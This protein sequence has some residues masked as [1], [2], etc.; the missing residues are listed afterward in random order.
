MAAVIRR[1]TEL[2]EKIGDTGID[3]L[4]AAARRD[5]LAVDRRMIRDFLSTGAPAQIHRP[6]PESKGKTGSEAQGFRVQADLIDFKRNP[7]TFQGKTWTVI[8]VIIDVQ[9]R[10]VWAK[11]CQTKSPVDIAP[12]FR[13]LSAAMATALPK[14]V[15]I[16]ATDQ[17]PEWGGAVAQRGGIEWY[18]KQKDVNCFV[19]FM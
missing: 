7:A 15:E 16:I 8:L 2:R 4:L 14:P 17:G 5:G 11:P 18:T 10:R 13:R 12:I 6:L 19:P 1:L 3:K 9:G